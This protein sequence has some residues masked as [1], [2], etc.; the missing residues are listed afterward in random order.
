MF[1]IYLQRLT[2]FKTS[3]YNTSMTTSFCTLYVVRHGQSEANVKDLYGLDTPLTQLG[4]EQASLT[5]QNLKNVH[6]D[7]VFSSDFLRAK[8][9]AEIIAKEHKL[10]ITT[11]K[12]LREKYMGEIEGR[13]AKEVKKEL[14]ELF[15][16][17]KNVPYEK[18]KHV[19][20]ALGA[21]TDDEMMARF[22][23]ELREI[24]LAY[25]GKTVLIGSHVSLMKTLLI[26]MGLTTHKDMDGQSIENAGYIKLRCD[27]IEF[28]IDEVKGLKA[29]II[30]QNYG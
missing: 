28:F 14:K 20:I 22:L 11:K 30:L 27:G 16:M 9:T 10:V 29:T 2:S 8:E 23:T 21:E 17:R 6:F 13:V 1:Q 12:A 26:H 3:C 7:A 25:A 24:S 15:D 18:W 4:K 19:R 5:A